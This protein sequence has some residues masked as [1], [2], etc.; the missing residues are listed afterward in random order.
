MSL[1][2]TIPSS[3]FSTCLSGS[4]FVLF[5]SSV[6]CWFNC[7]L[8]FQLN[9]LVFDEFHGHIT[10]LHI[11]W[12]DAVI[13]RKASGLLLNSGFPFQTCKFSEAP[14]HCFKKFPLRPAHFLLSP[15]TS[16]SPID[17][18][19]WSTA[20]NHNEISVV[21]VFWIT[22]EMIFSSPYISFSSLVSLFQRLDLHFRFLGDIA[23]SCTVASTILTASFRIALALL[24]P[25]SKWSSTRS[26]Y[27]R[28]SSVSERYCLSFGQA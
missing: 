21:P 11:P 18:P 8:C 5:A 13:F 26:P 28:S 15:I 1:S 24:Y 6:S 16:S 7:S 19:A 9:S 12:M 25:A 10:C 22:A 14:L 4:D 3:S 23:P 20:Q 27:V 17:L 2:N